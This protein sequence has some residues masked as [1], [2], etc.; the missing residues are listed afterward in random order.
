MAISGE[1]ASKFHLVVLPFFHQLAYFIPREKVGFQ[2][3]NLE[4]ADLILNFSLSFVNFLF[5]YNFLFFCDICY[6]INHE[7]VITL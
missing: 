7:I 6:V 4:I 5:Y 2:L 1:L 3:Q